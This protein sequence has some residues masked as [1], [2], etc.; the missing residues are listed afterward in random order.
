MGGVVVD[1]GEYR[2]LCIGTTIHDNTEES[3]LFRAGVIASFLLEWLVKTDFV[4]HVVSSR[5]Q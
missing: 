5:P 1:C 4:C 3:L 2:L